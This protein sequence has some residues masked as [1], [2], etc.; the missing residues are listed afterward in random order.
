MTKRNREFAARL[1]LWGLVFLLTLFTAP[2]ARA[3]V[4]GFS[5]LILSPEPGESVPQT[6]TMIALSFMDPGQVLDTSTV[7]LFIDGS[8]VTSGAD[9]NGD[10]I[11]W[12]PETPLAQGQ[13]QI[14]VN[15]KALDGSDLPTRSWSFMV[16]RPPEGVSLED[17]G[18]REEKKG[19]PAWALAQGNL[20]IQ[21]TMNNVGGEGAAYQREAP[22]TG[23][24]RLNLRGQLGGSWRYSAMT[25]LNSYES[26]TRQPIDRFGFSIRSKFMTLSLGD[27]NPRMHELILWGRRVRGWSLDLRAGLVNVMIVNGQSR[28]AVHPAIYS[29]DPT[30]L[31]RMGAYSQDLLAIRPYFGSGRTFQFGITLMKAR[32]DTLSVFEDLL[33]TQADSLGVQRDTYPSPKDNLVAG[34]DL[35][36]KA[37]QGKLSLRFDAAG[38]LLANDIRGGAISQSELDSL[39]IDAG[40]DPVDLPFDPAQF[41]DYFII[42]ESVIPI[43]PRQLTSIATQFRGTVRLGGHTIGARYRSIGGSY[44]TM[45]YSSLPRDRAG[46]RIQDSVRL[47]N[48]QLGVT[49]GWESY[50]DNLDD[51][52]PT[53]TGTSSLTLDVFWQKNAT[54]P[55]LSAGFREYGR[56]NDETDLSSGAVDEVTST[57]SA[58]AFVPVN[59]MRGMNSFLNFNITAIGR[60][61]TRNPLTGSNN[62]YYLVRLNNRFQNRPTEFSLTYGLNTSELTG[63]TDVEALTNFHRFLLRGRHAFNQQWSGTADVIMTR[64]ASTPETGAYGL[65]YLK[66]EFTGGAEYYWKA[67]SYASL[68]AGYISYTDYRRDGVDTS[69]LILRLRITQAF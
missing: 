2:I 46:W 26:H 31:F 57:Y 8:E 64:A 1:P 53:T 56:N 67:T 7:S 47:F 23:L 29:E 36:V 34:V 49:V 63:I 48:D 4:G 54:S 5:S 20:I 32:D 10:L 33:H 17:F 18:I 27:V 39:L 58:G 44:H 19:L 60:E 21:G 40:Q 68:R 22:F 42:N 69:S 59:F 35:S 38:S 61:D 9:V 45:G 66:T 24:A 50:D 13:H 30:R 3:Q 51:K 41:E 25:L 37:F 11:V 65:S 62:N 43:D 16:G 52:K 28:R 14:V 12:L 55:G 15:M 6:T